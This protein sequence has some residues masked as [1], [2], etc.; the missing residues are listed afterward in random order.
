[1]FVHFLLMCTS[2]V[3]EQEL[4]YLCDP[5]LK[6]F[7]AR[8]SLMELQSTY[9]QKHVGSWGQTQLC[10]HS[11][12]SLVSQLHSMPFQGWL[13]GNRHSRE[14][15][16]KSN[17]IKSLEIMTEKDRMSWRKEQLIW[18]KM[19]RW[20]RRRR[21]RERGRDGQWEECRLHEWQADVNPSLN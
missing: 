3:V 8:L 7:S 20:G 9:K 19:E 21:E 12:T 2:N 6:Q 11:G 15:V 18:S 1:M 4:M 5:S 14:P 17:Q 10:L 13:P 16:T